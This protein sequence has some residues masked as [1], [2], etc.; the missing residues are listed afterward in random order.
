MCVS[1]C[2]MWKACKAF[3]V[4]MC[5]QCLWLL[6]ACPMPLTTVGVPNAFDTHGNGNIPH[7]FVWTAASSSSIPS[8]HVHLL[9]RL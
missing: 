5:A 7:G 3:H 8:I 6:W 9:R 1:T 2:L 4:T